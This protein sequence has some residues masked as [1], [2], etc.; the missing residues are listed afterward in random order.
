MRK[1]NNINKERIHDAIHKIKEKSK[2]EKIPNGDYGYFF[3]S[4]NPG[5]RLLIRGFFGPE[6]AAEIAYKIHMGEASVDS[7]ECVEKINN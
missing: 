4:P 5:K 2:K 1:M 3:P 6:K 7:L